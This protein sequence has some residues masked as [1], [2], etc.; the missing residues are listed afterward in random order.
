MKDF[1]HTVVL[2]NMLA[3]INQVFD[4][5]LAE[6]NLRQVKATEDNHLLRL[7]GLRTD[8]NPGC[9][10]ETQQ[11]EAERAKAL[12]T[13]RKM[14][15]K[16][17]SLAMNVYQEAVTSEN[18]QVVHRDYLNGDLHEVATRLLETYAKILEE[19]GY[20]ADVYCDVESVD[21]A[22]SRMVR[23]FREEE[24]SPSDD[25]KRMLERDL[26]NPSRQ[27]KLTFVIKKK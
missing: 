8:S 22:R 1:L 27:F 2:D 26:E 6:L 12:E 21:D 15:G 13:C 3:E 16:A 10:I 25:L 5:K 23:E 9:E 20:K 24:E 11:L 19:H 7:A 4:G 18:R 17:E 14:F